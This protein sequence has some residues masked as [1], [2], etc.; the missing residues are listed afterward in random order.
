MNK[1]QLT[2]VWTQ[3]MKK[4]FI[5]FTVCVFVSGCAS[6]KSVRVLRKL[7]SGLSK[8]ETAERIGNPKI[9][10]GALRNKYGEMIEVWEYRLDEGKP[11]AQKYIESD[12]IYSSTG[13]MHPI[14]FFSGE[15]QN[16]WLYFVDDELV[17]WKP[18]GDW[19]KEA[20][21]I[22]DTKFKTGEKNE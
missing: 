6:L 19:E 22:Y 10:R 11:G 2:A 13:L 5:V 17:R 16:Y 7:S 20:D 21:R 12:S 14:L 3:A 9:A 15:I 4:L 18:A 1:K 8:Q